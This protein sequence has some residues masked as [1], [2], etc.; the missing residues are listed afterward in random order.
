MV[1]IHIIGNTPITCHVRTDKELNNPALNQFFLN[2]N[3]KNNI[4]NTINGTFACGPEAARIPKPQNPK[5]V[6]HDSNPII[7]DRNIFAAHTYNAGTDAAPI[8]RKM[9]LTV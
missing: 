7:F 3:R 2:K 4:S 5:N 6:T 9:N 8:R 1:I